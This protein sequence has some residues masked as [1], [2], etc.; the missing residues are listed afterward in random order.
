VTDSPSDNWYE[1]RNLQPTRVPKYYTRPKPPE[2]FRPLDASAEE[3]A[4]YG[5]PPRPDRERDP[6][7][8][9][10]WQRRWSRR[11]SYIEPEL[12]LRPS[13]AHGTLAGTSATGASSNWAGSVISANP[14]Q[15]FN[16]ISG[17]WTVPGVTPPST[18]P[19]EN[20]GFWSSV[21]WVG[22]D[23]TSTAGD[24][25]QAGTEQDY[26]GSFWGGGPNY[27]A[28]T[29]WFPEAQVAI[30]NFQVEPG[31]QIAVDLQILEQSLDIP[32]LGGGSI[33][34]PFPLGQAVVTNLTRGFWTTVVMLGPEN[35][36]PTAFVGNS[37]EWIVETP[38]ISGCGTAIP[39]FEALPFIGFVAF[40][41]A[42]ALDNG[43]N[44]V[45]ASAGNQF[46]LDDS[47]DG[48]GRNGGA[49][50]TGTIV[51]QGWTDITGVVCYEVG[52]NEGWQL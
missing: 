27:Y 42:N 35:G 38:C 15:T 12:L 39:T 32:L 50:G 24:V 49:P 13:R 22:L 44:T 14:G 31:D 4:N 23:G 5:V 52:T 8:F 33:T 21:T 36:S 48:E 16:Q 18:G 17:Q 20:A 47:S 34:L 46:F 2:G 41:F 3:L 43:G 28:W 25:F 19:F 51:A 6:R 1:A 10:S 9:A 30:T 37:A 7:A 29:E 26:N 45:W 40:W 11:L